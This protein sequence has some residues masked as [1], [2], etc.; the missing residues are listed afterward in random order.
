MVIFTQRRGLIMASNKG[1]NVLSLFDGMSG[2]Q[3]ALKELGIPVNNYYASEIDEHA[4]KVTQDNFPNTIQLGDVTSLDVEH[5]KTL[6][7]DLM[8]Y[9]APCQGFSIAGKQLNLEDPRSQLL[10]L[11]T[12][13]RNVIKPKWWLSENVVMTKDIK[14]VVDK[15]LGVK[16]IIIDSSYFTPARRLRTYWTNIEQTQEF[17]KTRK[18]LKDYFTFDTDDSSLL[19]KEEKGYTFIE[20]YSERKSGLI[21]CGNILTA[22]RMKI[23]DGKKVPPKNFGQGYNVYSVEGISS[24]L[25]ANG[26]GLAGRTSLIQ[27]DKEDIT[28]L[29]TIRKLGRDEA[30][31]LQGFPKGYT[32]ITTKTQALTMLGN[33]WNVPTIKYL[34]HD[35]TKALREE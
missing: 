13:I 35:L 16:G 11:A 17:P 21:H 25:T 31:V 12:D 27:F 30:E 9:G 32:K 19:L 29:K 23:V 5:L 28:N 6:D 22:N 20:N 1:I 24:T 10:F 3:Q 2:G 34:L 26:G 15:Y 4:I 8:L 7:I 33:G 18:K 14:E